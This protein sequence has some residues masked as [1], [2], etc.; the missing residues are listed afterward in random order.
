MKSLTNESPFLSYA[1]SGNKNDGELAKTESLC[2]LF[3]IITDIDPKNCQTQYL[4]CSAN[5]LT[6]V[7]SAI[8]D[9]AE[10]PGA[11]IVVN[12]EGDLSETALRK[13]HS[14]FMDEDDL[15][16]IYGDE[17][18]MDNGGVRKKPWFKPDWAPEDFLSC[19]YFGAL[20]AIRTDALLEA[21]TELEPLIP[22]MKEQDAGTS[23]KD[24]SGPGSSE[25]GPAVSKEEE[26]IRI[27]YM[28]TGWILRTS[29]AFGKHKGIDRPCP[30][31]RHIPEILFHSAEEGYP[32]IRDLGIFR[33]RKD[34]LS[35]GGISVIIPSKDH[36]E[37]FSRCLKTLRLNTRIPPGCNMEVILVDNGSTEDNRKKYEMIL[38][39]FPWTSYIYEET[40]FNF[41]R[42]CNR[43]AEEAKG[44]YFL[45]LNDDMEILEK[46][47]LEKLL[48]KASLPYAGAVGAKLL[49]PDSDR[50]QHAGITN[51]R[52]GPAHKLQFLSDSEDHYYGRN[53]FVHDMMGVT[54]ACL[55]V[56]RSVFREAGGFDEALAV[57]F[58]DVDLCF[59][60]Y[61]AG[62]YNI[63]R[64]DV[65]LF[66]HESLSRGNDSE[67]TAKQ[68]RLN[69][70]KDL[71]YEKHQSLYGRDPFYNPNLTTD[72]LET[73]YLPADHYRIRLDAPWARVSDITA[74]INSARYDKCVR[75]GME[76]A[77]DLFKWKYGVTREKYRGEDSEAL[78]QDLGY[79]FQGYT[80]VTGS[81]NACYEK[82][83]FL[84]NLETGRFYGVETESGYRPDIAK[85]IPDQ[86]NAEL[87]GFTAKMKPDA[88]PPGTY[89]FGM[90]MKDRTSK[91]RLYNR[92]SWT[93]E[94]VP[95][96]LSGTV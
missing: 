22:E 56:R 25:S 91:Q 44:D 6:K 1:T 36:P 64:N 69:R 51:L 20:C 49:Y 92:S 27:L 82:T 9:G 59:R 52:I 23:L 87:A 7:L 42:M 3:E 53:R 84:E 73:E 46:D 76:G 43:G 17:D 74:K 37:I 19:F 80:F 48:R 26:G 32:K 39:T 63:Q 66:H 77:M 70:E 14:A 75:V 12:Y 94:V 24:S 4:V 35:P 90:Y 10:A 68:S 40:E 71:L 93:L 55:M 62:Y 67:D 88:V 65:T 95:N 33:N 47:W 41:S 11:L 89:R 61:E 79:Y 13:I 58:N 5:L 31:V 16:L 21:F 18:V 30:V 15:I 81:D 2:K 96:G 38:E 34:P 86:V 78:N 85:N 29:G 60:I 83:L 54:G 50:I 28:L 8:R 45:F 57:A 72:M